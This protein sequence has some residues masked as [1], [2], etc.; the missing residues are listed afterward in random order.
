MAQAEAFVTQLMGKLEKLISLLEQAGHPTTG[1]IEVE[2]R[3]GRR[4]E[5]REGRERM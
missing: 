2:E 1:T 4:R 3:W 5:G